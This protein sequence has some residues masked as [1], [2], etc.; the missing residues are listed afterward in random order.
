MTVATRLGMVSQRLSTAVT[1]GSN[2]VGHR[3]TGMAGDLGKIA[4]QFF[5]VD[6]R[7]ATA[8]SRI[9]PDTPTLTGVSPVSRMPH[10]FRPDQ[11]RSFPILGR[12]KKIVG[13]HFPLKLSDPKKPLTFTRYALDTMNGFYRQA[14]RGGGSVRRPKWM[15]KGN[16]SAPWSGKAKDLI[17][18]RA[19]GNADGYYVQFAKKIPFT[20]WSRWVPVRIDGDNYGLLLAAKS[21]FKEAV[22]GAPTADLIQ[23]SCGVAGGRA[24]RESATAMHSY[25][26]GLDVHATER[27]HVYLVDDIDTGPGLIRQAGSS[28][29]GHGT[30]VE[31]DNRGDAVS[32]PWQL[33]EASRQV[34]PAD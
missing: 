13:V 8:V 9:G 26:I 16:V 32:S 25:G 23:M 7:S 18:A 14:V 11:V 30:E 28:V 33:Y 27:V 2:A 29:T 6:N 22:R 24:A 4:D 10:T 31:V 19:H 5:V 15:Y 34:P 21:H 3:M 1:S 12:D 17:F 20:K